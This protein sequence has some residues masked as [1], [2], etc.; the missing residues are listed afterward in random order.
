MRVEP[1]PGAA[2][3][4]CMNPLP[5][6][7]GEGPPPEAGGPEP[8]QREAACGGTPGVG[9]SSGDG[10]TRGEGSSDGG[11]CSAS[12]EPRVA[13]NGTQLAELYG[14]LRARAERFMRDQPPGHTLQVTALVH[15]ACL[16]IFGQKSM[17]GCERAHLLAV[18]THAMRTILID[19]A[20]ARGRIKRSPP[21]AR[22]PDDEIQAAYE[23][24]AVDLLALNEAMCKLEQFDP[25]MARVVELH[26]FGGLSLADTARA[27]DLPLRTL[28]R[29]W[30]VTRAWLRREIEG[31]GA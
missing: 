12:P 31:R 28:E 30:A 27:L 18:A 23:D 20:R 25:G 21:G 3:S 19:H 7:M 24:R 17:E 14:E 16:K 9:A 4:V 11:E 10:A 15:E 2:L 22:T 13:T 8:E 26:F 29:H 1:L 6:P 5:T